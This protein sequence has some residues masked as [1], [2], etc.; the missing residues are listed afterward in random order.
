MSDRV[1][2]Q[3]AV[4]QRVQ[5]GIHKV[6]AAVRPTL[7][8]RSRGVVLKSYTHPD[9]PEYLD[10]AGLIA[11]RIIELADRDEDIG[12]MLVRK[13]IWTVRENAGDGAALTA[14][15]FES[16]YDEGLK[17]IASGG[18]AARLRTCLVRTMD[19]ILDELTG[20]TTP[21][22]GRKKLTQFAYGVCQ[23]RELAQFLGEIFDIIGEWG[24]LD[25][26]KGSGREL[27]RE[28]VE[29]M[30]WESKPFSRDMLTAPDL[31]RVDLENPAILI[32]NLAIED[33]HQLVPLLSMVKQ[34]GIRSL[35]MTAQKMSDAAIGLLR[36]NNI[37]DQLQIVAVEAPF[38]FTPK[39][40]GMMED[41]AMLTGG[42]PI[43]EAS[44]EGLGHLK[45][46]DLGRVRKA[47]ADRA[48]FGIVGGRG[49]PR[50]VRR[51]L[52]ELRGA[53]AR[54]KDPDA[55]QA[56]RERIG[57]LTGGSATLWVGAMTEPEINLRK[58]LAE[59]TAE[60]LRG[61][62]REG[63]LP[64]GGVALLGCRPVLRRGQTAST[65]PDEK[66]AYSILLRASEEPARTI[67]ANA[68]WDAAEVMAAIN[69]AGPGS[70]FDVEAGE[71]VDMVQAGILDSA[72]VMR[73]AVISA[74]TTAAL[75][76]SLGAVVHRMRLRRE[77]T[78]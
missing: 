48:F 5:H 41:L 24:Q 63:V 69:R 65:D 35:L 39:Q 75:T 58:D 31:L 4:G 14:V 40:Q 26:R 25:V 46:E 22:R 7:G 33:P 30:Y 64:G 76:L 15:L 49:D 12:A 37:P 34:A 11:R 16:I 53:F 51:H 27:E 60:A 45:P 78:P 57:R 32:T 73:L 50:A 54:A 59:R 3:P 68:G 62:R 44:G 29:G 74:V 8:P 13:A 9:I 66:A 20:V 61:A 36:A 23:D 52:A 38:G 43:V 67:I 56:W 42:R 2:F 19:V 6:V 72:G 77:V 47:W 28:Y 70:G 18:S 55:R 1:V 71:V 10:D 21:I 17:Y